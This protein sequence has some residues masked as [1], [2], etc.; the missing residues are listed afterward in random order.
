MLKI[1]DYGLH[2]FKKGSEEVT[3]E[4]GI[5]RKL[6]GNNQKFRK[7]FDNKLFSGLLYRAPELLRI[8]DIDEEEIG[9]QKGDVYSFGII[10]YELHGRQG[11]FG[12]TSLTHQEILDKVALPTDPVYR[13]PLEALENS[14]DFVRDCLMECWA[15]NPE[16]RTDFK[17]IRTRLRPMKKGM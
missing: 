14:F 5:S 17:T 15:E 3:D 10:L 16:A 7:Q 9:S 2:E 8:T 12:E 11:P 4:A 6:E 13:P 1:S